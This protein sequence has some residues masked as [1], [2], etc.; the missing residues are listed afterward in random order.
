M[1]NARWR[2]QYRKEMEGMYFFGLLTARSGSSETHAHLQ[3]LSWEN[4]C[5]KKKKNLFSE[6]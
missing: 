2:L 3:I 1:C 6:K 4:I 5:V